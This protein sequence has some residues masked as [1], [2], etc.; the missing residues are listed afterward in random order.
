MNAQVPWQRIAIAY[1]VLFGAVILAYFFGD[2][3]L[4]TAL[5][6][7][8][9]GVALFPKMTLIVDALGP[10]ASIGAA[11]SAARAMARGSLTPAESAILRI[12]CAILIAWALK[13]ELKW[14]FGRTWPETWLKPGNLLLGDA[15]KDALGHPWPETWLKAANPS[16]FGDGTYGF[17]PIQ[18]GAAYASFPSGHTTVITAFAGSLWF[19]CPR[20]RWLG[21]AFTACVVIGLLGADYHWL[22]D[23]IAG[24]TLG[25]TVG[26]VA[27]KI[28]GGRAEKS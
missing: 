7:Y 5:K 12:S 10:L 24:G 6:P 13:E 1:A 3:Q 2:R 4:A 14:A 20:A 22:S 8:T 18:G 15:A 19:L 9:G 28:G 16:Y 26:A 11:V 17:F 23:I 25:S 21:V 27:A